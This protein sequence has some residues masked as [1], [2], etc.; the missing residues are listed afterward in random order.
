[1]GVE[2]TIRKIEGRDYACASL[3]GRL[4]AIQDFIRFPSVTPLSEE[5]DAH[6]SL[7]TRIKLNSR[8]PAA[9][10]VTHGRY[11]EAWVTGDPG[12]PVLEDEAATAIGVGAASLSDL[13]SHSVATD[14]SGS[15]TKEVFRHQGRLPIGLFEVASDPNLV[16]LWASRGEVG[17]YRRH[18]RGT[19]A[20]KRLSDGIR[21]ELY[22]MDLATTAIQYAVVFLGVRSIKLVA[23]DPS[24]GEARPGSVV[25][26]ERWAYP[27]DLYRIASMHATCAVCVRNHIPV[28]FARGTMLDVPFAEAV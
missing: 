28:S 11:E 15:S 26:G 18:V 27:G 25:V 14:L 2:D 17:I 10:T 8:R 23:C 21:T 13:V 5:P 20:I 12:R 24:F 6:P 19:H 3:C 4:A 22:A 7:V 9:G 16:S 1:M